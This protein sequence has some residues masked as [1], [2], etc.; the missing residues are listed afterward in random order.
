MAQLAPIADGELV[1][2]VDLMNHYRQDP[3]AADQRYRKRR[4]KIQGEVLRLERPLLV[5]HYVILIRMEDARDRFVCEVDQPEQFKTTFTVKNGEEMVGTLPNGARVPL[6]KL[7]QTVVLEGRCKGLKDGGIVF[8]GA[9]LKS[10][11]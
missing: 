10:V 3:V 6:V 5:S 4:F 1:N 7:G 11:Q 2:A 9:A 8:E